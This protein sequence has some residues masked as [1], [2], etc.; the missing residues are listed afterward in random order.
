MSKRGAAPAATIVPVPLPSKRDSLRSQSG[1]VTP[2]LIVFLALVATIAYVL[3][4]AFEA[5][6][7]AYGHVTVTGAGEARTVELPEGEID[8]FYAES[9]GPDETLT[10]PEGLQFTV[11][12]EDGQAVSVESR[13]GEPEDTDGGQA[14]VVGSASVPAE[15]TY[16][17]NVSSG[18]LQGRSEPQLTFGQAPLQAVGDRFDELVEELKGPTGIIVAIVLVLL[19]ALPSLQRAI[20]DR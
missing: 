9:I 20:K 14:R 17:V 18:D 1:A 13:G 16:R 15:G 12:T 6:S 5:D 19:L 8:I 11:T 2:G 7:A 3:L 10:L 4:A